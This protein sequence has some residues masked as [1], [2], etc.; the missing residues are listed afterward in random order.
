[1]LHQTVDIFHDRSVTQLLWLVAGLLLAI[2][3][4][5]RTQPAECDP[6]SYIT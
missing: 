6:L 4:I 3:N 5:L 1:M 2:H